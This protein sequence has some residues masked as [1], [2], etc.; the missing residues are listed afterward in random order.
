MPDNA[1]NN[2]FIARDG[3]ACL[4]EFGIAGAVQRYD[5]FT[6]ELE[7]LR[8]MA[9]ECFLSAEFPS[10]PK[11]SGI[12]KEGDVYSL[13]MTSFSVRSSVLNHSAA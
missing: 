12:Q 11:T 13:T 5:F 6:Y 3:R 2:I 9:P 1:Q 10:D 4:G 8:Y 7:T